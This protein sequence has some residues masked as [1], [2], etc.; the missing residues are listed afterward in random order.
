[1][2]LNRDAKNR[3]THPFPLTFAE[4]TKMIKYFK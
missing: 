2:E 3:P 4:S 1:M